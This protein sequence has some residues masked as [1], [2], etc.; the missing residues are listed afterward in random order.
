[1]K[2]KLTAIP[3][4]ILDLINCK[5]VITNYE[6]SDEFLVKNATINR[7]CYNQFDTTYTFMVN[8][9]YNYM[10]YVFKEDM[11]N[12]NIKKW[13]AAANTQAQMPIMA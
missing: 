9:I 1:M 12:T 5:K 11:K 8:Q 2:A 7:S 10:K 13:W 4:L 6:N 3:Y